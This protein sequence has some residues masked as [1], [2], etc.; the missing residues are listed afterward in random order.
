MPVQEHFVVFLPWPVIGKKALVCLANLRPERIGTPLFSL[1]S[2]PCLLIQL[3]DRGMRFI[4]EYDRFM[5]L[6]RYRKWLRHGQRGIEPL[7]E[8][9]ES[10]I[11]KDRRKRAG[12]FQRNFLRTGLL[13]EGAR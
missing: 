3:K 12:L 7:E 9:A 5:R 2:S 11:A 4:L 13:K 1:P 8:P 6:P 10:W